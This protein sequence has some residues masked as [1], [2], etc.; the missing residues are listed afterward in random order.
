MPPFPPAAARRSPPRTGRSPRPGRRA[1]PTRSAL[2]VVAAVLS[3]ATAT[4]V[5]MPVPGASATQ[6]GTLRRQS[7]ATEPGSAATAPAATAGTSATETPSYVPGQ[8]IV[9]YGSGTTPAA[10]IASARA[11]GAEGAAGD[12]EEAAPSEAPGPLQVVRVRAGTSVASAVARLRRTPGVR[13]AVPD[14]VARVA[15]APAPSGLA[16]ARA[17]LA[18]VLNP[19]PPAFI[20]INVGAGHAAGDWEQLQWN[21]VGQFGIGAPQ[22]WGNL[23]ADHAAG[24]RGVTV[25]VLDTGVAFRNWKR[26]RR[27]PGFL[28][29]QFVA[30]RDFVNRR[31]PPLDR[32]GHGTFVAGEIAEATDIPYGLP[33]LAYGVKLM[34]VRVLNSAGEGDALTIAKG[35]RFA[36]KHHAQVINLS[37]EFPGAISAANVPELIS[38]LRF[39]AARHVFVAAA[40]GNDSTSAI[41]YPARASGVVAVGATTEHGCL[42][43]YSNYGHHLSLVAPGGGPDAALS[44]DPNCHPETTPGRDIFQVSFLGTS[45]RHFGLP[46][47]YEGTSMATPEVAGT[48]AL[49][50][51][52]GVLGAHPTPRALAARLAETATQIG[53]PTDHH[54]YGAGLLNAAAATGQG[55]PGALVSGHTR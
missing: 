2:V 37:L 11:A 21:F 47:G 25:A 39:A 55:G 17:R 27:S 5:L 40:A 9:E 16:A 6:A 19:T 34:P 1:R 53:G 20:P 36:V 15:T 41:P 32:N 45:V 54:V 42:A 46:A 48:A 22:A 43:D 28:R 8:V 51:A 52:S 31:T 14:Y 30:G 13:Y 44:D 38:A 49:V 24:G 3:V 29:S 18:E 26:F 7:E 12:T 4:G 23:I 35:I 33:G 10:Q 50:I